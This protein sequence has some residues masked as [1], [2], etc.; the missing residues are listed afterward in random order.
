MTAIHSK[1]CITLLAGI[2]SVL[3][4]PAGVALADEEPEF[5]SEFPIGECWFSSYGDNRFFRLIPG[6]QLRLEGEDE[7]EEILVVKTV[8][9][10]TEIVRVRI[11]DRTRRV[12]T[13]V[14]LEQEYADG[15]VTEISRNYYATCWGSGDVYYFGE[16][17]DNYEDGEI[18][19][20]DGSWRADDPGASPGIIMPGTFLLGSRYHQE[21]APGVAEDR[22]EH[23]AMGLE[24][25]VEAGS[26]SGCVGVTDTNP[27][28]PESDGDEKIYCP[29]IGLVVDE[30]IELSGYGFVDTS[31]LDD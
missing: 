28:D 15:E 2:A 17:V 20:H 19:N 31:G 3:F 18:A 21:L 13:R 9:H 24:V 23:T 16:E 8:L 14:L 25:D 7:G 6:F 10:D 29:R 26:F 1:C 5:T 30:E 12:R 4:V 22:A 27:L 11:G